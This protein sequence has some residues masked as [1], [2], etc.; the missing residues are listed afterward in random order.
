MT[1]PSGPPDPGQQ[2]GSFGSPPPPGGYGSAPPTPPP[3]GGYGTPPPTPPPPGGYGDQPAGN[4]GAPPPGGFQP[5]AVPY[6]YGGGP[7]VENLANPWKRIAARIVDGLIF[8]VV[9]V[10]LY[11]IVFAGSTTS[12]TDTF[13]ANDGL[14]LGGLFLMVIVATV[15][16]ILYEVGFIAVKGQTPGKML[17]K[18][19]VVRADDHQIPGWGPAFL[20]WVPN[21][22]GVVPF[23]GS[24]LS[25]VLFIWAL[26]NLFVHERRQT[27]F[28][29][30][31]KT[32]VIEA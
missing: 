21:L 7:M 12:T 29:L 25:L 26:V 6:Q 11:I 30:L 28:D 15:G 5:A 13:D 14:A 2:P 17:L 19:K 20:R 24:C 23:V 32:V 18:V 1:D 4:W 10:P 22:V 16:Q 31:A 8:A 27:P 9:L 3:P